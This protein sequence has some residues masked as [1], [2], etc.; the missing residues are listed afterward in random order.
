MRLTGIVVAIV[1]LLLLFAFLDVLET[2]IPK[3][4]FWGLMSIWIMYGFYY[5]V[6]LAVKHGVKEALGERGGEKNLD[7]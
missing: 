7:D 4:I 6:K 1:C 3:N 5:I 2:I